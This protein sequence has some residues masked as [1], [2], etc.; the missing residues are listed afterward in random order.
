MNS[1]NRATFR[2][3]VE[4]SGLE[5]VLWDERLTTKTAPD[6]MIQ[7]GARREKRR[8]TVDK[9]AAQLMLQSFLDA[10]TALPPL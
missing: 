2:D 3:L 8:V 5:A 1:K 10:H 4:A 9:L 6:V 7:G